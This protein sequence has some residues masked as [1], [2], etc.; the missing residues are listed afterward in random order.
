MLH[1]ASEGLRD[2]RST[3]FIRDEIQADLSQRLDSAESELLVVVLR[4]LG[5]TRTLAGAIETLFEPKGLAGCE[6]RRSLRERA[7]QIEGKATG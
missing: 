7:K 4:H 1:L 2:G 3:R 6:D 5:L